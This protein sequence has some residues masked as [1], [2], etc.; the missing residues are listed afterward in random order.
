MHKLT[1][2][3]SVTVTAW[4]LSVTAW[5]HFEIFTPLQ[6]TFYFMIAFNMTWALRTNY[7]Q[8]VSKVSCHKSRIAM[9]TKLFCWIFD[10]FVQNCGKFTWFCWLLNPNT[11]VITFRLSDKNL[12]NINNCSKFLKIYRKKV[13]NYSINQG[14][15]YTK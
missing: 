5:H 15:N 4:H 13:K 14:I 8:S 7:Y 6:M 11:G 10:F 12:L 2:S 1:R 9:A 3:F